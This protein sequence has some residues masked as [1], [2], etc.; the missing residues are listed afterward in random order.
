MVNIIIV[1]DHP[2]FRM[3]VK[4]TIEKS[5]ENFRVMGEASN[6]AELFELLKT[7][8]P[9]LILLDIV[10]PDL[11]GEEIARRLKVEYPNIKVLVLS[12]ETTEAA[13]YDLVSIGVA[14]FISK[15]VVA[16]DIIR[17]IREVMCG[18]EYYG[19][20]IAT[21]LSRIM[22]DH[23]HAPKDTPTT[24]LTPRELE[25]VERLC[26][27]KPTKIISAELGISDRTVEAHKNNLYQKLGLRNPEEPA[28][29]LRV[30][31]G[32]LD[33]AHKHV[34][35]AIAVDVARLETV[36]GIGQG[37][38]F[39]AT[40]VVGHLHVVKRVRDGHEAECVFRV[41]AVGQTNQDEKQD[42]EGHRESFVINN[43]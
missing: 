3:G 26:E 32:G 1:E 22:F 12:A 33:D 37:P 14:G 10:L 20:D 11:R 25:V 4:N 23:E 31:A 19:T 6:A 35:A 29:H 16:T 43:Q 34:G 42:E 36:D 9:D 13:I 7:R 2:L 28:R 17:A 27:G 38:T 5:G 30:V 18:N 15:Q 24:T 39:A 41:A 40:V 8:K 21:I